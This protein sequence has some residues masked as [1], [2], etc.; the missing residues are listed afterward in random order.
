MLT[1]EIPKVFKTG[2]LTPLHKKGKD[3][4]L[5]TNY[6]GITV[7]SALGK[8]FEYAL[9][10]KMIDLNNN[11]SELQFGFTQ[12]LSPIMAAFIVSEGIVH[13]KQHNLNLFLTTLDS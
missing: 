2:I 13:A 6:R 12:G 1:G 10:D 7:T 8:V 5:P 3:S 9:L 4:T 11:Q